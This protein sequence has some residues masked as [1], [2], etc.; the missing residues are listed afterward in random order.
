MIYVEGNVCGKTKREY[1]ETVISTSKSL[2]N[3]T[4]S[5]PLFYDDNLKV[6]FCTAENQESV[7]ESLCRQFF[8][9]IWL[10]SILEPTFLLRRL[11][12]MCRRKFM[13]YWCA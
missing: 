10:K 3:A 12:P 7:Y 1:I 13:V 2:F 4:V 11:L 8:R 5:E 9:C 6:A